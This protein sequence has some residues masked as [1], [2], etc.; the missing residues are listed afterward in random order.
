MAGV[1]FSKKSTRKASPQN[2]CIYVH[3]VT[4]RSLLSES[5]QHQ[6]ATGAVGATSSKLFNEQHQDHSFERSKIN[7]Q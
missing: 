1:K 4:E 5:D 7:C 6:P 2:T 3:D